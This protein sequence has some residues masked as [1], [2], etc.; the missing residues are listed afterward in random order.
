M[1]GK[2]CLLCCHN[3]HAEVAAVVAAEGWTD[4]SVVAFP[5][6]CG[7]PPLSWEE[8]SPQVE[9][10][11]S[12][13]VIFGRACLQGLGDPSDDWPQVKTIQLEECFDLV[14]GA[15]FVAEAIARD[16]YLITPGWLADWRGNLHKM[17]FNE[18]NV[19]EF[20]QD[21]AR[22]LLLL[23]TGVAADAGNQ[24]AEFAGAAG[25]PA[26]RAAVGLDYLRQSLARLVAEWRLD[27][28]QQQTLECERNF[29]RE[30]AGH[31]SAMDFLG[32]LTMLKDERIAISA[33]SEMFQMLFAPQVFHYVRFEDGMARCDDTLP[34]DLSKQVRSLDS[35][36]AWTDS[37][38]GF[39]LRISRA[40]ETLG[41]VVVDR[42]E[43]PEY[44][45]H[46]LNLALSF[47]GVAGL[48]I[49]NAHTYRRVLETEE[50]LR[51]SE[52]SLKMA[53]AM[54]HLGHWELDV[55]SGDIHWSDETY[56]IL[57]YEPDKHRPSFSAFLQA[58]HPDDRAR[59]EQDIDAARKGGCFDIEFKVVLPDGR[60]RV[61]HGMGE[62]VLRGDD[63]Q[64]QIIGTIRDI[65][66][67]ER[68]ELLG[69]VQ[70][71]TDQK[72]LQWRLEREA[73]TDPLTGCANRR[74]FLEL[75]E[76][77]LARARRY[78]EEVSVLM[79]D[80]DHF[81]MINDQHGHPAG[82]LVLQKF[83]Q[84]CQATLRAEDTVGRL[85]GEE[86]AIL[87]PE[88]GRDKALEVAERLCQSVAAAGIATNG[89]PALHFTTSIGVTSLE[90][91][92]SNFGAV[93]SRAD[94]ALYEAKRAGRNRVVAA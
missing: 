93:L 59:V 27:E 38:T 57:G 24:L 10:D 94:K 67:P 41:I 87:L 47:A 18:G 32:R 92:D 73:R 80:L 86:F 83:V 82:D 25:L 36:W 21:F 66:T 91:E 53:Q 64:P 12:R 28:A 7:R 81:K 74:H 13:I 26:T 72:E 16:A 44:R 14:A 9:K 23:D 1:T 90:R 70:D 51:K 89:K 3:F 61:L 46:Y 42:F 5:S 22:E 40:K 6:R 88:S 4:V 11:C 71:I 45:S 62:V 31:K 48:A 60:T 76:H 35:D 52:R 8:L 65:T 19:A 34:S 79:L 85:G 75:A 15:T 78:A 39:L 63:L 50:A 68:T 33:I 37:Q 54:A 29:N 20:F 2:L 84:V 56:R 55:G 49:D 69:V 43:Y 17:G 30:L 77:E 58:I